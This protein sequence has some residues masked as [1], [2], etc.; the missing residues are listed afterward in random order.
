MTYVVVFP[1]SFN[2]LLCYY[3]PET[4][5]E[6]TRCALRQHRSPDEYST[7]KMRRVISPRSPALGVAA[8][9]YARRREAI[10]VEEVGDR[11]PAQRSKLIDDRRTKSFNHTTTTT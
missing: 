10:T 5:Q 1:P 4:K 7:V 3:I 6:A 2:Q 8:H 9:L 11:C